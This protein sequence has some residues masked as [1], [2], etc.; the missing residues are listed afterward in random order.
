MGVDTVTY[1]MRIGTFSPK[2]FRIR[3]IGGR[4]T[5]GV[6]WMAFLIPACII[7]LCGIY[8]QSHQP[9]MTSQW[10]MSTWNST[11][12][13]NK[14]AGIT[15]HLTSANV[16]CVY[17]RSWSPTLTVNTKLVNNNILTIPTYGNYTP[18][19]TVNEQVS[20]LM[21]NTITSGMCIPIQDPPKTHVLYVVKELE[22][23]YNVACVINGTTEHVTI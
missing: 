18:V 16:T 21:T 1:R 6:N 23:E 22:L 9:T 3:R 19:P 8:M 5:E 20:Q 10:N 12:N 4:K 15:A 13:Y 7:L 2:H 14:Q 17:G 11:L